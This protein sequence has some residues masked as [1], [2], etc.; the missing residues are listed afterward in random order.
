M[1][2]IDVVKQTFNINS[3]TY[4]HPSHYSIIFIE[5]GIVLDYVLA[6]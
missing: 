5:A 4:I 3:F 6:E 1:K 2:L